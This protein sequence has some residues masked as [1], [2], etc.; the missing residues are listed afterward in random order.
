MIEILPPRS[1]FPKKL[2][3]EVAVVLGML[4]R[5]ANRGYFARERRNEDADGNSFL[6]YK[7][8]PRD[9][10]EQITDYINFGLQSRA[11]VVILDTL[12]NNDEPEYIR[13]LLV[14]TKNWYYR[15]I[16]A[17]VYC[18]EKS[19]GEFS[20]FVGPENA[21]DQSALISEVWDDLSDKMVYSSYWDDGENPTRRFSIMMMNEASW[22]V[23]LDFR[24]E[25]DKK[26]PAWKVNSKLIDNYPPHI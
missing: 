21:E 10:S 7:N 11:V 12:K 18:E 14:I 4:A 23:L 6:I 15:K 19:T 24:M 25:E 13:R 1:E 5:S 9:V 8:I 17:D 16:N 26:D 20:I 2:D 22:E 3:V